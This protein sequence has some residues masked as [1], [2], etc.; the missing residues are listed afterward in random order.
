MDFNEAQIRCIVATFKY[1]DEC[2]ENA[3]LAATGEANKRAL[4]PEY[5]LDLSPDRQA[6]LK[7]E[8]AS[9]R[10][11]LQS[12]LKEQ[13]ILAGPITSATS[14]FKTAIGFVDIALEEIQPKRLGGY[15]ALSQ[16]GSTEISHLVGELK[17][18]TAHMM[19]ILQ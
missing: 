14:A 1:M 6:A 7:P 12:F 9:F 11:R 13:R 4:C 5:V 3:G 2:L 15:G 18:I 10:N 8:L 17:Q 16:E 19:E